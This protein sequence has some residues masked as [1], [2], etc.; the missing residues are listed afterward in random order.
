MGGGTY[1]VDTTFPKGN[2]FGQW[3]GVV[4]ALNSPGPPPNLIL[5]PVADSVVSVNAPTVR[6]IYDSAA[7]H[8][9][10][11]MSFQTPI[12]GA[13][14]P[15]G[16][17]GPPAYCGKAVFTDLHTGGSLLS[18]VPSIPN[19][20]PAGGLSAQQKA[21]EFLFFDLSACVTNDT[22]PPPTPGMPP[23]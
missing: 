2:T 16:G 21:L 14:R 18:T 17:E 3:L 20:C 15:A 19:G 8:D 22:A 9:V 7:S 12:G 23:Q 6:W 1:D 5:N 13:P 11:Y 4:G 10:K